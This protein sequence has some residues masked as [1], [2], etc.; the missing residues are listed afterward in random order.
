MPTVLNALADVTLINSAME[1]VNTYGKDV[2]PELFYNKIL[3]DTIRLG[4]EHYVHYGLADLSPIQ[5]KAEKL[6]LRRWS[7]LNA[8][9]VPLVEG[10]P[11][12]SDK[13]AMESWELGVAQY[14]RYMEFTD[15]VAWTLIDPI[16]SHYTQQYSIV[17]VETLDLLAREAL[18]AVPN[19]YYSGLATSIEGMEIGNAFKPALQDLRVIVLG[20]KKRLVKPRTNGKFLVIGT[21]DFF[22]DMVMDPIVE[23]FLTINQSTKNVYSNTMIPDLFDLTFTETQ[24]FEDTPEFTFIHTTGVGGPIT[25]KALR[26]YRMGAS[27]YEYMTAYEKDE[28]GVDTGFLKTETD[29]MTGDKYRFQDRELNAIPELISWDLDAIN[30]DFQ[31]TGDTWMPLRVQRIIVV[32]AKALIRTNVEGRDNAKMYVKPL[33]SAGVLDPIDQRQSIGFKIDAVG[34]GVERTDAVAI[35]HCVPSQ[36]NA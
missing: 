6:Q 16:I 13:G 15:K 12:K 32:G 2:R 23:K 33:G 1:Y 20:F 11:P 4:K 9:T 34:F 5:G 30:T 8:H 36:A 3:L 7:P 10:V 29:V 21:P 24:A 18:L 26:L 27:A 22:F 19:K 31:L 25:T 35:Y 17:A 28:D 14:G